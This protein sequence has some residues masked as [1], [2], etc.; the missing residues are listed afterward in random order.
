[1]SPLKQEF[2]LCASVVMPG[3][4]VTKIIIEMASFGLFI[5]QLLF[6]VSWKR[7]GNQTDSSPYVHQLIAY[8]DGRSVT[9][10]QGKTLSYVSWWNA[11]DDSCLWAYI[12]VRQA[13]VPLISV[14]CLLATTHPFSI[15]FC[16]I[17]CACSDTNRLTGT[18]A[19][20]HYV[21]FYPCKAKNLWGIFRS[22][23]WYKP[24]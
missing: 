16:C 10:Q 6:A 15:F 13:S 23:K 3:Y 14:H 11:A 21:F 24:N 12:K 4:G 5:W 1:M 17:C 2:L 20:F 7:W 19:V 22:C 18:F 9:H 8:L